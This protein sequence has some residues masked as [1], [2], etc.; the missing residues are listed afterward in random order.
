MEGEERCETRGEDRGMSLGRQERERRWKTRWK[1]ERERKK[2]REKERKKER[3]R[4][5][6]LVFCTFVNNFNNFA[7]FLCWAHTCTVCV[8]EALIE[9]GEE[10]TAASEPIEV[11]AAGVSEGGAT[12]TLSLMV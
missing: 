1:R 10:G 5:L 6:S 3:S 11:G 12:T 9:Y 8:I 4:V 2:E 7:F